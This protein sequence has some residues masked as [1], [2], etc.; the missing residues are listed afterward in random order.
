MAFIVKFTFVDAYGRNTSRSYV[1]KRT[2][3]ADALTDIAALASN[4]TDVTKLGLVDAVITQRDASIVS[5]PAS[6]SNIDE[7]LSVK[8]RGNDGF[9]YDFNVPAPE[10]AILTT[11][12]KLDTSAAEW[13]ALILNFVSS[14]QWQVNLRHPTHIDSTVDS[15]LDK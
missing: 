3:L 2:T 11:D 10:A 1:N 5:A 8:L 12:G 6:G 4:L 13:V 9:H 15:S 7:N 14:G